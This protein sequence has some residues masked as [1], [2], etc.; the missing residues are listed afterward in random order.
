MK[1]GAISLTTKTLFVIF[2]VIFAA[3]V[4]FSVLKS[5][6][7]ALKQREHF[8]QYGRVNSFFTALL[9]SNCL[10][11]DLVES[12]EYQRNIKGFFSAEKMNTLNLE[13][14]DLSCIDNF[15]FIY[16]VKIDDIINR[17]TWYLGLTPRR[18]ASKSCSEHSGRRGLDTRWYRSCVCPRAWPVRQQETQG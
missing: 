11:S 6:T 15:Y 13:N 12:R 14:S 5:R 2:I 4:T 16:S 1:K 8:S 3:F 7:Q 9:T 18:G 10:V 17:K